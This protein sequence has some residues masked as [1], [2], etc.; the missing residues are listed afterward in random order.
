MKFFKS[1]LEEYR[2]E[3]LLFVLYTSLFTLVFNL[4]F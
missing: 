2:L 4:F 3:L 1:K